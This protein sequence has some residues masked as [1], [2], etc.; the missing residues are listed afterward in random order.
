MRLLLVAVLFAAAGCQGELNPE[1]CQQ[2]TNDQDCINAGLVQVDASPSCKDVPCSGSNALVCDTNRGGGLCV[3][4]IPGNPD[5]PQGCLCASDDECH[6][7]L[8]SDDC[9][10]GGLCLPDFTCVGGGGGSGSGSGSPDNLLYAAPAGTGDCTSV[11][12]PCPLRTALGK[13][14][15]MH[16]VIELAAGSYNEGPITI[17]VTVILI[18]PSPG[19][20]HQYHDPSDP[21]GR[22]V[23]TGGG[24][25]LSVTAGTVGLYELT[26]EG[27][28]GSAGIVCDHATLQVY[29]SVVRDNPQEGIKASSCAM[30][31]ERSAFT[32][33]GTTGST[34][35]AIY[36]ND[37]NPVA[38]RNNFVYG[39]GNNTSVKGAVHFVGSTVGDFRF[40]TVAYNHAQIQNKGPG[41]VA[42]PAPP[43]P[44]AIGGVLCESSMVIARDDIISKNDNADFGY[45]QG[46]C[47]A[48][49]SFIGS[50]P[51]LKSSTDLHATAGTPTPAIVNNSSSDCSKASGYDIDFDPRPMGPACDLGADEF[52]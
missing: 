49:N 17:G 8:V 9:G 50:D 27:S 30:S 52:Q 5:N 20:G 46:G 24:P 41:G 4:C 42:A 33:N 1:W 34:Y 39:N 12:S 7:C 19:P 16:K 6:E 10:A 44:L 3:Q 51:K 15:S 29:H 45:S 21:A 14:D 23:I 22:A 35:E 26:V 11:A 47:M 38:I 2:H 48:T 31:I 40:N 18:G 37:C 43:A 36:A 13:V 28:Q 25:V 32:K